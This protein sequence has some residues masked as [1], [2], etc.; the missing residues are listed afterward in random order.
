MGDPMT[1]TEGVVNM[2]SN[3]NNILVN[4]GYSSYSSEEETNQQVITC[5]S[6]NGSPEGGMKSDGDAIPPSSISDG[7]SPNSPNNS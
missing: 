3:S 2:Y 5:L 6:P 1:S 4:P 7:N